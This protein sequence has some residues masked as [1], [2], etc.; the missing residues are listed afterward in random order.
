MIVWCFFAWAKPNSY[1]VEQTVQSTLLEHKARFLS[2][3]LDDALYQIHFSIDS[4]GTAHKTNGPDCFDILSEIPFPEHPSTKRDF[5][6]EVAST[7]NVLYPQKLIREFSLPLLLPGL[8]S[9]HKEELLNTIGS[10]N[11]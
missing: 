1:L 2:C 9:M 4:T 7:K 5:V 11:R 8:F 3:S 6:W 10:K